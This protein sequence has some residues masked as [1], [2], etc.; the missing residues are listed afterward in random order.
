MRRSRFLHAAAAGSA[1]IAIARV[2][3]ADAALDTSSVAGDPRDTTKPAATAANL[4]HIL[5]GDALSVRSR[6]RLASWMAASRTGLSCI[7]AGVP[8]TWRV[9]DKTGCGENGTRNDIAILRRRAA[10]RFWSPHI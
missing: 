9:G 3:T 2:N 6:E 1:A 8:A 7:R 10:N 5:L 4:R